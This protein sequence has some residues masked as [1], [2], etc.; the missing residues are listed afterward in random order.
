MFTAQQMEFLKEL[1]YSNQM[2]MIEHSSDYFK[3]IHDGFEIVLAILEQREPD[4]SVVN[5]EGVDYQ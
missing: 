2:L 4:L 3:G 5:P 1:H